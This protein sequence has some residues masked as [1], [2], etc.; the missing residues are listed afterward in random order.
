MG[1][2][3]RGHFRKKRR[4]GKAVRRRRSGSGPAGIFRA[5][6]HGK[7][8][9]DGSARESLFGKASPAFSE[10]ACGRPFPPRARFPLEPGDAGL[11][12][13]LSQPPPDGSPLGALSGPSAEKAKAPAGTGL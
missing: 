12:A 4:G 7:R 3:R 1:T 8:R 2:A 13:P 11:E 5:D 10:P 6:W 9:G